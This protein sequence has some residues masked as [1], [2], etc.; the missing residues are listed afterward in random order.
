MAAP[1][2]KPIR[3]LI[4]DDY[5]FLLESLV[6]VINSE[7]DMEVVG[8]AT[9]LAEALNLA[10]K[11]KPDLVVLDIDLNGEN[12]IDIIPDL[13]N[14][15]NSKVLML[16]GLYDPELYK[17]AMS[18]GAHGIILKGNAIETLLRVIKKVDQG[19]IWVSDSIMQ[20]ILHQLSDQNNGINDHCKC[21]AEQKLA[22]LPAHELKLIITLFT[23]ES[24][25]NEEIASYLHI[26]KHTLKN[27]LTTIY[28]KFGVK[29]R[30]E[31]MNYV[32]SHKLTDILNY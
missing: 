32:V 12:G 24:S 15:A 17:E 7:P 10:L 26:G 5:Q 9:T 3:I 20:R 21:E 14:K 27:R 11:E 19:K 28:R 13:I 8:T 25:T 4:V 29:T 16:T 22:E 30:V 31:L 1:N 6:L 18:K 23:L 2:K